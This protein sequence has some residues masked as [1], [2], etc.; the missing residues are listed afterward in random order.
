VHK[1]WV[2]ADAKISPPIPSMLDGLQP[3]QKVA[4]LT[5]AYNKHVGAL[6]AIE[7]SQ[8]SLLNLVLGIYSA[9]LTLLVG[10][11]KDNPAVLDPHGCVLSPLGFVLVF[12]G[13][14]LG[15]YSFYMSYARAKARKSVRTALER[16]DFAFGFF[17]KGR[18]LEAAPLYPD[19]FREYTR[20]SF[21]SWTNLVICI[22][23]TAFILA[24]VILSQAASP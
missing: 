11:F 16:I 14:G 22:P 5:T 24:I 19:S 10:L 15:A 23:A 4:I 2:M 9:A 21:L 18:Y 1:G 20:H 6:T 13:L 17:E 7:A 8:Q 12:A 3:E